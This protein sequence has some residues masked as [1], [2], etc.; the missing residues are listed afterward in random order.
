METSA[1]SS[2][3][4]SSVATVSTPAAVTGAAGSGEALG[5]ASGNLLTAPPHSVST[6]SL[7]SAAAAA[8]GSTGSQSTPALSSP[9]TALPRPLVAVPPVPGPGA[10]S[11]SLPNSGG[12]SSMHGHGQHGGGVWGSGLSVHPQGQH[13]G[14]SGSGGAGTGAGA[15]GA[16]PAIAG[17]RVRF[18]ITD[19]PKSGSGTPHVSTSITTASSSSPHGHLSTLGAGGHA[20]PG[21]L[22]SSGGSAGATVGSAPHA[23]SHVPHVRIG[24]VAAGPT[25]GA[26]ALQ[27]CTAIAP[28][29][30]TA[31]GPGPGSAAAAGSSGVGGPASRH[32]NL[33]H[34]KAR[35]MLDL[36]GNSVGGDLI[37]LDSEPLPPPEVCPT[38]TGAGH[39]HPPHV[40]AAQVPHKQQASLDANGWVKFSGSFGRAPTPHK[41]EATGHTPS[42]LGQQGAPPPSVAPGQLGASLL[43]A[44]GANGMPTH[45]HPQQQPRQPHQPQLPTHMESSG[46]LTGMG[47]PPSPA[48]SAGNGNGNGGSGSGSGAH[49]N[50]ISSASSG[51]AAQPTLSAMPPTGLPVVTT[52]ATGLSSAS[53]FAHFML[54]GGM[55]LSLPG[56]AV[57]AG[58]GAAAGQQ[59]GGGGGISTEATVSSAG[60]TQGGA[61][62][63]AAA[64]APA[65]G[66]A[67]GKPPTG[68]P[69]AGAGGLPHATVSAASPFQAAQLGL[70]TGPQQRSSLPQHLASSFPTLHPQH[71]PLPQ[72]TSQQQQQQPNLASP[73]LA[74]GQRQQATPTG[75]PAGFM[76]HAATTITTGAGGNALY[77]PPPKD[78]GTSS[79]APSP[80]LSTPLALT[81]SSAQSTPGNAAPVESIPFADLSPWYNGTNA[82]PAA[83]GATGGGAAGGRA[84]AGVGAGRPGQGGLLP[85]A[86]A[87]TA[88]P[89]EDRASKARSATFFADLSPFNNGVGGPGGGAGGRDNTPPGGH[90]RGAGRQSPIVEM[91][92]SDNSRDTTPRMS[93]TN[94]PDNGHMLLPGGGA[95]GPSSWSESTVDMMGRLRIGTASG[96]GMGSRADASVGRLGSHGHHASAGSGG[97]QLVLHGQSMQQMHLATT[98]GQGQTFAPMGQAMGAGTG[99]GQAA[100]AAAVAE[101]QR[102]REMAITLY[103]QGMQG[104]PN[105]LQLISQAMAL[106]QAAGMINLN[107]T[108]GAGAMTNLAHMQQ[109]HVMQSPFGA[110]AGWPHGLG[111]GH[112]PQQGQGFGGAQQPLLLAPQQMGLLGMGPGAMGGGAGAVQGPGT[113]LH[114]WAAQAWVAANQH[115]QHQ[116]Q[117]LQQQVPTFQPHFPPPQPGGG[118]QSLSQQQ[119][120]QQQQRQ[121]SAFMM[122]SAFMQQQQGMAQ[123]QQ[124]HQH[125]QQQQQ[126]HMER[127]SS[128]A[129]TTTTTTTVVR[130]TTQVVETSAAAVSSAQQQGG[131]ASAAAGAIG[132]AHEMTIPSASRLAALQAAGAAAAAGGVSA[133]S[134]GGAAGV[135]SPLG[136]Q[137]TLSVTSTMPLPP[138]YKDLEIDPKELTLGQR[139]GIGRCVRKHVPWVCHGSVCGYSL[140]Y[141]LRHEETG[142]PRDE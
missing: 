60:S 53:P 93:F 21:A 85:P 18:T 122:H 141:E 76:P 13:G 25:G 22:H 123:Q 111:H 98:T 43:A 61:A 100:A 6:A 97:G 64:A 135:S 113:A 72:L 39:H 62:A 68:A 114:P 71:Q 86:Q 83:A 49:C 140:P 40:T 78:A 55:S 47:N 127:N 88:D 3:S 19:L 34:S 104:G 17:S 4:A 35:S 54:P 37:R 124:L 41:D 117:Q 23:S 94:V 11:S 44:A 16:G 59:G 9:R 102:Q 112:G 128:F 120:Q 126:A 132:L 69:G 81:A 115:Q 107:P 46:S 15:G 137:P 27:H 8:A 50:G 70:G 7:Q 24:P 58:V 28:P 87:S 119:H 133:V 96:T 95:G 66:P 48:D 118:A 136:L 77:T 67:S 106:A 20:A 26:G 121:Q 5:P 99:L 125:Q 89:A 79:K 92:S 32:A 73:P 29:P 10:F 1:V 36:H 2:S 80:A 108:P 91:P 90:A 82:N 105:S 138:H 42:R 14:G 51:L 74:P 110:P 134:D 45:P 56:A 142:S 116:Q 103:Q 130:Q 109:M 139:I 38:P 129:T 57:A 101:Q 12:G 131:V 31:A 63:T 84:G 33:P 65:Q 52:G 75:L 30:G